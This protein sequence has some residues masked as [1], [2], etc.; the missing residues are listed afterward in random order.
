MELVFKI[1][2]L[3]SRSKSSWL[4]IQLYTTRAADA[5]G[6]HNEPFSNE[7]EV[8]DFMHHRGQMTFRARKSLGSKHPS[9]FFFGTGCVPL[10]REGLPSLLPPNAAAILQGLVEY[11]NTLLNCDWE[12]VVETNRPTSSRHRLFCPAIQELKLCHFI[13][14]DWLHRFIRRRVLLSRSANWDMSGWSTFTQ[15]ICLQAV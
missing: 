6:V 15:S 9:P 8:N 5:E 3:L 11:E 2:C 10:S 14:L 1:C 13:S 7:A 4:E 12:A